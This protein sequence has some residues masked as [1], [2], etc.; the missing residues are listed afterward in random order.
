MNVEK[1]PL[2]PPEAPANLRVFPGEDSLVG[3]VSTGKFIPPLITTYYFRV[4]PLT[5]NTVAGP[6][7]SQVRIEFYG[8]NEDFESFKQGFE[9][10]QNPNAA[11]CPT[12][13]P[14][15]L[16]PYQVEI[17]GYHGIIPPKNG[18]E[19]CYIVTK[20]TTVMFG[21][22]QMTF[23]EGDTLCPP[24]PKEKSWY[25]AVID[26]ALDGLNWVST[27]YSDLKNAV[28][29][30]VAKFVP[31]ALCGKKCLGTILDAGLMALGIPP[32]IPNFDQLMTEGL[33]Y[34]AAQA[35][36]Q[37]GIPQE[38]YDSI[39]PSLTGIA[40]Q[41]ALSAAEEA[42]KEEAEK[43][44]KAGLK[45]G[46]EAAQYSLSESI[47]WIPN[48]VPIKADPLGD[49]QPST[50]LLKVTRNPKV[51]L[52]ADACSGKSGSAGSLWVLSD[53]SVAADHANK[54]NAEISTK[55]KN[56]KMQAGFPYYLYDSM[57][58]PLPN[59]AL[60]ESQVVPVV[61]KPSMYSYW[62]SPWTSLSDAQDAW[63]TWYW[64]GQFNLSVLNPCTQGDA[65]QGSPNQSFGQ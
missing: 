35:A 39:D 57:Y 63:Y 27:A 60:G 8:I 26:F 18:H 19:G 52:E 40:A 28:V 34:L 10:Q 51:P 38:V 25:E 48:G 42:W 45:A 6:A 13:V 9:C 23:K 62:G 56:Q 30:I 16:K 29:S 3:L 15:P 4:V 17:V 46:L 36:G 24:K 33:D 11:G 37:L 47:S 41:V 12:P 44:I 5:N 59:L 22:I 20:G 32:S 54:F 31:D 61:L 55:T 1:P 64:N 43:Q 14:P 2:D 53:V 65:I 21:P 50:L 58:V 7:S 49:Y